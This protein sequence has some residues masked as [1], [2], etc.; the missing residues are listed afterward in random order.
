MKYTSKKFFSATKDVAKRSTVAILCTL[1]AGIL[2]NACDSWKTDWA[3]NVDQE[4]KEYCLF[5]QGSYWVYQDSA[6]LELDSVVITNVSY[7]KSTLAKPSCPFLWEE[8]V[9][10]TT[11]FYNNQY[12]NGGYTLTSVYCDETTEKFIQLV[13]G[14]E[15]DKKY[16]DNMS[17]NSINYHNGNLYECL[18]D[19][20]QNDGVLYENYHEI[21]Q[22]KNNTFSKVKV[23]LSLRSE[24]YQIRTY[25]AENVGIIRVEYIGEEGNAFAIRNLIK[26]SVKPY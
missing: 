20:L 12:C 19:V 4:S 17:L 8:Y 15:I 9:M 16:F 1:V 10:K 21:Y 11:C 13:Y 26:Y 22:I 18:N 6:T 24:C 2:L 7:N 23:F 3:I 25:W 5:G 14:N